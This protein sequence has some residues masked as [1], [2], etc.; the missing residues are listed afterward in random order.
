[1]IRRMVGIDRNRSAFEAV[2]GSEGEAAWRIRLAVLMLTGLI[3]VVTWGYVAHPDLQATQAPLFCCYG[4]VGWQVGEEFT[5]EDIP[6][7]VLE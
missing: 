3:V 7:V 2:F 6:F 1:M 5:L 4:W